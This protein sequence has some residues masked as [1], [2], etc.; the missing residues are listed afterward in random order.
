MSSGTGA[1][2]KE[3]VD[4][5]VPICPS[6]LLTISSRSLSGIK[7]FRDET[8]ASQARLES[9]IK[10]LEALIRQ[11]NP[12]TLGSAVIE[13][14]ESVSVPGMASTPNTPAVSSPFVQETSQK[15]GTGDDEAEAAGTLEL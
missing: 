15:D 6:L 9:R 12:A 7:R 1:T 10:D 13:T 2:F 3:P 5:S 4:H 11:N 14:A 8:N